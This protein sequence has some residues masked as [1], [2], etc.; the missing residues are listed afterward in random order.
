MEG[1]RPHVTVETRALEE[2]GMISTDLKLN[3]LSDVDILTGTFNVSMRA[4]FVWRLPKGLWPAICTTEENGGPDTGS[5]VAHALETLH[6]WPRFE[7]RGINEYRDRKVEVELLAKKDRSFRGLH[8]P[9]TEPIMSQRTSGVPTPAAGFYE[10]E[11]EQEQE[12]EETVVL[13]AAPGDE[14]DQVPANGGMLPPPNRRP[15]LAPTSSEMS[16][17]TQRRPSKASFGT[18]GNGLQFALRGTSNFGGSMLSPDD[19]VFV[20]LKLTWVGAIV[21]TSDL[22]DQSCKVTPC[23]P[24]P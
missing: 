2:I 10:E 7:F 12:Q 5:E 3:S 4:T 9:L 20:K 18:N 11:Q 24:N 19:E 14:K 13:S 21:E 15:V 16:T 8:L 23:L 22:G 17:G 1:A 6:Q